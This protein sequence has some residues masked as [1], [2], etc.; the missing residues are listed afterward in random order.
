MPIIHLIVY[1]R[2]YVN[3]LLIIFPLSFTRFTIFLILSFA[4]LTF[5]F[6]FPQHYS[7]IH[8]PKLEHFTW[9]FS[10]ELHP[11]LGAT[12]Y[13]VVRSWVIHF[14][15]IANI[16]PLKK[17]IF[18]EE[19]KCI[20][21]FCKYSYIFMICKNFHFLFY[22]NFVLKK[23]CI[24]LTKSSSSLPRYCSSLCQYYDMLELQLCRR[25][26]QIIK[27]KHIH[28]VAVVAAIAMIVMV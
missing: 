4:D 10:T 15:M 12:L 2:L 9:K 16:F 19:I 1:E 23:Y 21:H 3:L 17:N 14:K 13:E 20:L 26:I 5:H 25:D 8:L 24:F 7:Q 18:S 6:R 11:L 27:L 28:E 22:R